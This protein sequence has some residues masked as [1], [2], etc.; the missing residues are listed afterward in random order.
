LA[1]LTKQQTNLNK[2]R[3]CVIKVEVIHMDQLRPPSP[4]G[5]FRKGA[6]SSSVINKKKQPAPSA[7]ESAKDK[8]KQ[9][10]K[11]SIEETRIQLLAPSADAP[12]HVQDRKKRVR[13]NDPELTVDLEEL[14]HRRTLEPAPEEEEEEEEQQQQP[15]NR[16]P[17]PSPPVSSS[18]STLSSLTSS[19]SLLCSP[20]PP[21]LPSSSTS[22]APP[23][24]KPI[25]VRPY[26]PSTP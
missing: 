18:S 10:A 23:T 8:G 19:G 7:N 9:P 1:K 24:L 25:L 3:F 15:E 13:W 22:D 12:E 21:P 11:Q 17:P 6:S 16:S 20:S 2:K 26:F 14:Y 5:N 4:E